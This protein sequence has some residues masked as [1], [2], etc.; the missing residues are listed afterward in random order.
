MIHR[1]RTAYDIVAIIGLSIEHG[2]DL[3]GETACLQIVTGT[4]KV[5]WQTAQLLA[6]TT[7]NAPH[8]ATKA[9]SIGTHY[10]AVA[11]VVG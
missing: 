3:V 2:I 4:L 11:A 6:G 7:G 1:R 5:A 10:T 8:S 9:H